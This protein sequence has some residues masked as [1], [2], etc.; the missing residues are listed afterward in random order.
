M[1]IFTCKIG[2]AD[3][4]IQTR[5]L[6]GG[7]AGQLTRML[8]EQGV[9]VFSVK[10]KGFAFLSGGLSGRRLKNKDL[11]A[12]NQELLVLIRAG[13]PVLQTLDAL[14]E[15]WRHNS[16]FATL[17]D[18]VRDDVK[19]GDALSVAMGRHGEALPRLY[20][21]SIQAGE[22]TGDLVSVIRRYIEFQKRSELIRKKVISS[23]FYPIIL[24]V[25]A[26]MA[27]S[28]LLLYVVPTFSKIYSDSG[29]E[30]PLVTR[31]LIDFTGGLRKW[32]P[33]LI[34]AGGLA[35]YQFRRWSST[36]T[37]RFRVDRWKLRL[38]TFGKVF[39][40][41]AVAVF[42]R[43][44]ATLLGS[45]IPLVESLRI[46]AGTLH[47]RYMESRLLEAVRNVEEGMS[48]TVSL[49]R[50][51]IF[52]PLALRMLGIGEATGSLEDM[53]GDIAEYLESEVEEKVHILTTAIEPAIM[54][55][56]GVVV[57]FI[58]IAMYLPIFKIG[59]TVGG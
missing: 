44:L 15:H 43:T 19:G 9:H 42:S 30:L 56:M 22:R 40:A 45:G 39:N 17:L 46:A 8:E 10:K 32:F 11:L 13:M 18:Q 37:G 1:A 25:V 35:I 7:D 47:N 41:Y 53:L 36:A 59:G 34:A 26:T 3:G 5:E 49:R 38:P 29:S 21:A 14:S 57:G 48:L 6:E 27:V 16:R 4:S 54:V 55:L 12:F 58:I 31:L 51:N 2:D 23:L 28:M 24:L 52:P 20:L 50:L 33:L